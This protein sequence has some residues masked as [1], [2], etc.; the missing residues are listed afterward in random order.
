MK[1][2]ASV[3]VEKNQPQETGQ[4]IQF[5]TKQEQEIRDR[6]GKNANRA[7]PTFKME[8]A[9]PP[10]M[11]KVIDFNTIQQLNAQEV[12]DDSDV[13]ANIE[14]AL[15]VA[16]SKFTGESVWARIGKAIRGVKI[17]HKRSNQL[18]QTEKKIDPKELDQ[19]A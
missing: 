14:N 9:T 12:G 5:P 7:V 13:V 15:K 1:D 3:E 11:G 18:A 8:H 10:Q 2:A 6:V 4:I 16:R 19:A 17:W